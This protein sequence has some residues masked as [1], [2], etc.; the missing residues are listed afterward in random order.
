MRGWPIILLGV[1]GCRFSWTADI[2]TGCP[3]IQTYY[4]DADGDGWGRAGD[5]QLLCVPESDY[6][7]A[8]DRDCDDEDAEVTGRV[9]SIC[10][11]SLVTDPAGGATT[12]YV[13]VVVGTSEAIAVHPPTARVVA[14]AAEDACGSAGW[15]GDLA[16]LPEGPAVVEVLDS[17]PAGTGAWAGWV[18]VVYDAA[19]SRW[20]WRSG[21]AIAETRLCRFDGDGIPGPEDYDPDLGFLAL[22]K[23]GASTAWCLGTPDQVHTAP[24]A[25]ESC[26]PERYAHFV[27]ERAPISP[28]RYALAEPAAAE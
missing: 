2:D 17:L 15:G 10:P 27:C 8:N 18:A 28:D 11:A 23:A 7:V 1:A 13:G 19:E 14:R 6:R 20:E 5:S 25:G 26:Y 21:E 3:T 24:C 9:G 22:V 16:T 12:A 4:R